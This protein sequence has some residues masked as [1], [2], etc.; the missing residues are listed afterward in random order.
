MSYHIITPSHSTN[1]VAP[2]LQYLFSPHEPRNPTLLP[3]NLVNAFSFVFLIRKP[4][5]SLPSLYRC[6]IPP[7][8]EKTG[9]RF[10]DSSE[11]GYRETRILLDYLYPTATRTSSTS[12]PILVDADDLLAHPESIVRT[13]CQRLAL[14]YTSSMLTWDTPED[15]ALAESAFKKYAGYHED[16]LKSTGLRPRTADHMARGKEAKTRDEEDGEWRERYGNE[17]A[18]TIRDAV[19]LCQAD[20]EYLRQFRIMP[21]VDEGA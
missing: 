20:Y 12:A 8:S 17:A 15:Y 5:A 13:V 10:L 11:L 9:E 6:F 4:S 2:S 7:L 16:A 19:D 1:A 18:R 3:T 14:P 21:E